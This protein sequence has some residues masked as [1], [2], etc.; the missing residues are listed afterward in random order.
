MFKRILPFLCAMVIGL[1]FTTR[2][3]AVVEV[4]GTISYD[5][6][7]VADPATFV[8]WASTDEPVNNMPSGN[9]PPIAFLTGLPSG[10]F[11]GLNLAEGAS[12][13]F[14]AIKDINAPA[15]GEPGNPVESDPIGYVGPLFINGA[16]DIGVIML[17]DQASTEITSP[18]D[19]ET[20]SAGNISVSAITSEAPTTIELQVAV[21]NAFPAPTQIAGT[22]GGT[23]YSFTWG[24]TQGTWYLRTRAMFGAA[25]VFS[26]PVMVTVTAGQVPI[27]A[28]V[29]P[30]SGADVTG[31]VTVSGTTSEAMQNVQLGVSDFPTMTTPIFFSGTNTGGNNYIF[32]W[33]AAQVGTKYLQMIAWIGEQYYNSP[34]V[35]VNVGNSTG[36]GLYVEGNINYWNYPKLNG[37]LHVVLSNSATLSTANTVRDIPFYSYDP[38]MQQH[39]RF[40]NITAGTYWV[41]AYIDMDNDGI[42]DSAAEAYGSSINS[43]TV[44]TYG[45]AT[46][47]ELQNPASMEYL[48]VSR[49]KNGENIYKFNSVMVEAEAYKSPGN[50]KELRYYLDGVMQLTATNDSNY[51]SNPM[52]GTWY[53]YPS[54]VTDGAHVIKVEAWYDTDTTVPSKEQTINVNLTSEPLKKICGTVNYGG[55]LGGPIY[56]RAATGSAASPVIVST[57]TMAMPGWFE[58]EVPANGEYLVQAFKDVNN[59]GAFTD[60]DAKSAFNGPYTISAEM[61]E[62]YGVWL[63]LFEPGVTAT[64][65]I[66]GNIDYDASYKVPGPLHVLLYSQAFDPANPMQGFLDERIFW[67]PWYPAWY[68]FEGRA[69]GNYYVFAYIDADN[70]NMFNPATDPVGRYDHDPVAEGQQPIALGQQ[71]LF[72]PN[73]GMFN[74]GFTGTETGGTY[75][76]PGMT[77]TGYNTISGN[78]TLAAGSASA[79][80][81]IVKAYDQFNPMSS[82]SIELWGAG[83][84]QLN[85]VPSYQNCIVEAFVD[86][87]WNWMADF[88]EPQYKSPA[89]STLASGTMAVPVSVANK[90]LELTQSTTIEKST[91]TVTIRGKIKNNSG[92]PLSGALV[93]MFDTGGYE[94]RMMDNDIFKSSA[95]SGATWQREN[96]QDYNF[97][98]ASVTVYT[99]MDGMNWGYE[100]R[101]SKDG[102]KFSSSW[103]SFRSWDA[104]NTRFIDLT[105]EAKPPVRVTG[106]SVEPSGS[107]TTIT[108]N[109]DGNNDRA[110]FK[111]DYAVQT[112][113]MDWS[114]SAQVKLVIDTNKD[115]QY[116]PMNW[117][118][119]MMVDGKEF[120]KLRRSDDQPYNGFADM[121]NPNYDKNNTA[122][123]YYLK[124]PLSYEERD[125]YSANFDAT[126]DWWIDAWSLQQ[127]ADWQSQHVEM[128][129]EGRD[130]R[131]Q[132]LANGTY[133]WKLM[134]DESGQFDE[135]DGLVYWSSGTIRVETPSIT[136]RVVELVN[137]SAV[138]IAGAKV[139]AGGPSWGETYTDANGNFCISGL[140]ISK[141]E[142][143]S[144][145][146]E[147]KANGYSMQMMDN[148]VIP[149]AGVKDLG[150]I[151][152]SKGIKVSGNITISNPPTRGALRDAMGNQMWDLW[153]RIEAWRTDGPGW[154]SSEIRIPLQDSYVAGATL[155]APYDIW[156]E[157]G[158]FEMQVNVAGYVSKREEVAIAAADVAKDI[159]MT[160]AAVVTGRIRL[161]VST[162]AEIEALI[163]D[164]QMKGQ[165]NSLWININADSVDRKNHGWA[166][167]SFDFYE[168]RSATTNPTKEFRFESLVPGTTY[169]VMIESMGMFAM[170]TFQVSV[171]ASGDKDLGV[172]DLG[173]G[174][175]MKGK[176]Y[177]VD[178][179][180]S[181]IDSLKYGGYSRDTAMTGIAGSAGM[182]AFTGAP[183]F[184]NVLN[185]NDYSNYGVQVWVS[186]S[187]FGPDVYYEYEIKGLSSGKHEIE[188][189]GIRGV[190][191][192]PA[193]ESRYVLVST[194]T[195]AGATAAQAPDIIVRRPSGILKGTLTDKTGT[196]DWTKAA[197][198]FVS[199]DTDSEPRVINVSANGTFTAENVMTGNMLVWGTEY[200]VK[201]GLNLVNGS[202]VSG[203]IFG[204][205]S[206]KVSTFLK[207][208]TTQSGGTTTYMDAEFKQGSTVMMK[209]YGSPAT[210]ADIIA[211][212]TT[213][214]TSKKGIEPVL[215]RVQPLQLKKFGELMEQG[216][217]ASKG[218]K[219]SGDHSGG[220]KSRE[221]AFTG[222]Y[223]PDLS[224]ATTAVFKIPGLEAGVFFAYPLVNHTIVVDEIEGMHGMRTYV[225]VAFNYASSPMEQYIVLGE[226]ETQVTEFTFG[227]GVTLNGSVTRPSG[228]YTAAQT[229]NITLRD[230]ST[231]V[232]KYSTTL[233][234]STSTRVNT[235]SFGFTNVGAGKYVLVAKSED[236][237]VY[238]KL[239]E[240]TAVSGTETIAPIKLEKGATLTGRILDENGNGL[241]EGAFLQCEAYPYVDGSYRDS[242]DPTVTI[243]SMT[244]SLG[245]FTVKNLPGGTY[246][247]KISMNES[248]KLNLVTKVKAGVVVPDVAGT[249]AIDAGTIQLKKGTLIKGKVKN[250][251]GLP[252]AQIRV[253]AF[254]LDAQKRE[255]M[256]LAT[257][258]DKDGAFKLRGVDPATKN[259]EI[260]VN[261]REEDRSK[262]IERKVQYGQKVAYID[263]SQSTDLGDVVLPVANASV[264]GTVVTIDSGKITLPF[265]VPGIEDDR[266]PAAL[267]LLQ[268]QTDLASGDPM[269]GAKMLT[270]PDGTFTIDG[271][272]AGNYTLK[273]FAKRY[274]TSVSTVTV[275]NA[276]NAGTITL[277][278][279]ATVTGTVRTPTG[280]KISK[281]DATMVM[282]ASK[283]FKR[284]VFG[285]LNT[286]PSTNEVDSFEIVGLEPGTQYFLALVAPQNGK[287]YV[288]YKSTAA[289]SNTDYIT[290]SIIY[291]KSTPQF[292]AKAF[293][294]SGVTGIFLKG[295]I[296]D[297]YGQQ[298]PIRGMFTDYGVDMSMLNDTT[299]Y[300]F[301]Y[302]FGF[303]S[304][305]LMQDSVSA[306]VSTITA[307]GALVPMTL[308]DNKKAI[309]LA[310]IPAGE[311]TTRGWFVLR[312][313]G[314]NSEGAL[315]STDYQFWL[316][317][318]G[319]SEKLVNPMVGGN[320]AL[321][322][323]DSTGIEVPAGLV[324]EDDPN[325]PENESQIALS[326]GTK[327]TVIKVS[328]ATIQFAG[329]AKF[330]PKRYSAASFSTKQPAPTSYPGTI[331]SDMYDMQ[332]K[333][334][335]GP[336]A[337]LAGNSA[338]G[339]K[340]KIS[341]AAL[342]VPESELKLYNYNDTTGLWDAA[343]GTASFDWENFLMTMNVSH[344]S[345]YAVFHVVSTGTAGGGA[346][347]AAAADLSNVKV[348]PNPYKNKPGDAYYG[349]GK[350][351]FSGLTAK[352]RIRI[353][354]IA[355]E[356]IVDDST[357]DDATTDSATWD[358]K[359]SDGGAVASGVYIYYITNP[360]NSSHKAVGKLAIIK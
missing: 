159:A 218:D 112:Q 142:Y 85:N 320:L 139:S 21:T 216:E 126:M 342:T 106:L 95:T 3:F 178:N 83:Y 268:D 104:G 78:I 51:P 278:K 296:M 316:G 229:V 331:M 202:E 224:N 338:V 129:W 340:I 90:N 46:D 258:T 107:P 233:T 117:G 154:F 125:R 33:P 277:Q 147:A 91:I 200:D 60:A 49:P 108:P 171:P 52:W 345:K 204:R 14:W 105:L 215:A 186:T 300:D 8:V 276:T 141:G 76:E 155:S 184:V 32:N 322:E 44:D 79:S 113:M 207:M 170:K 16:Q 31:P 297:A 152:L 177:L 310:Y 237:K 124:G 271:L 86:Y 194:V 324:I 128:L 197:V 4:S 357:K 80:R 289:S 10:A 185:T 275:A 30:V 242:N 333:L 164:A 287:V 335:T 295:G 222:Q 27:V 161:P 35:G 255:N 251:N 349:S 64:Y 317:E 325:T 304:Q 201:P 165:W 214:T 73:F 24:A 181:N 309:A 281:N 323:G 160:K 209:I 358:L 110:T 273:V 115:G 55:N 6:S 167:T 279:G 92:S 65:R 205:P 280:G 326:S 227:Q 72:V 133:G 244:S 327:V 284:V 97:T 70:N 225:T 127:Q 40:D 353:F 145:H 88:S 68:S 149:E 257:V 173:F 166:G 298:I 96:G 235:Q 245:Q 306:I 206:G 360:D 175:K 180:A 347:V 246:M 61:S 162:Q 330:G 191:M 138:P 321:G 101:I 350:I 203:G 228:N 263:V 122:Y 153:G 169:N 89:F 158:N 58:L 305:P 359:N 74:P 252:L 254:P 59:D 213:Y 123:E 151:T 119:F 264:S 18:Y 11:A 53:W 261:V 5:G 355:G 238:S 42:Y 236:Y 249:D 332:V 226:G 190:D 28:I 15:W 134:V 94:D 179:I 132:A 148:V 334:V 163:T 81:I 199:V 299:A 38:Y 354:N 339:V 187:S 337:T 34:I 346:T 285:S 43:I 98:I 256:Y 135:G 116:V 2:A 195:H 120:I 344:F 198:T 266:Y 137:G 69:T 250:A 223:M 118:M 318:D 26:A 84:Y 168:L 208:I 211:K 220:P 37:T 47:V 212:T 131:W 63:D 56:V 102:Y 265:P 144:Y 67:G 290:H 50:I 174:A 188:I 176:I 57:Y 291:A 75:P 286:N 293:K 23:D 315:G 182:S 240:I 288:D 100:F 262:Q 25:E 270:A 103:E 274:A 336:L 319:R 301:Y 356:L 13:Y 196:I 17:N 143:E 234:Y 314:R 343:A 20:L 302:I 312:F 272:V 114:N 109:N 294:I 1:S 329:N 193:L 308:S 87:N 136:G 156:L 146:F 192:S 22:G 66:E 39:Y 231:N 248:A 41:F 19:G 267:V 311:D 9:N 259:W 36:G 157:P 352:V 219:E 247:L 29:S 303:A 183:V 111:F 82:V 62:V 307:S 292:E 54:D 260:R 253:S 45:M 351:T 172:I 12:Y 239:M 48:K 328:D 71:N 189:N 243:S 230:Q 7:M 77:L 93:R 140:N 241:Y 313:A 348:Y 282:A 99:S 341:T 217:S 221:I 232:A 210:I 130:N 269:S 150:D 283:D 121:M